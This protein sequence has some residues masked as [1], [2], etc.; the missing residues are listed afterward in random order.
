TIF[1][2]MLTQI[3]TAVLQ[4]LHRFDVFSKVQNGS[5]ILMMLGNLW[6]AYNGYGLVA[7]LFWNL[8]VSILTCLF[9]FVFAKR[10]LPELSFGF[11]FDR[12]IVRMVLKYSS[13]VI[14]YQ[15]AANAFFLFER[16]WIISKLGAETL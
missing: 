8:L 15:I 16:S 6:L 13:G 5:S 7:L 9:A 11:G 12:D 1:I 10:L 14:G 4:G 3:A 2:L